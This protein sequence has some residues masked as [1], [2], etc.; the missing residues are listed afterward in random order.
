[1]QKQRGFTLIELIMV[2]SLGLIISFMAFQKMIKDQEDLT[3]SIAGQQIKQIG[4]AVNAYISNHY[5]TLSSLSNSTGSATDPGPRNCVSSTGFCTITVS[6]LSNEGLLP[7]SYSSQNIFNSGYSILIKRTGSAPYY[8]VSGL[9]TTLSPWQTAATGIRFDLLGKAMQSAGID[10]G[11]SRNTSN[12]MDGY[13][14]LWGYSSADF[15]NINQ[16]GL[17]GFITGYGATSY[18]VFLRRDGTLP[19]TGALNMGTNDITNAKNINATGNVIAGGT[20]TFGGKGTF[21]GEISAKNGYGDT[22][23]LGG[24]NVSNDYELR[25]GTNKPLTIYSP[26]AQATDT[27]LSVNGNTVVGNTLATN[28]LSPT[29]MPA[30][31]SGIRTQ[32]IYGNGR[33]KINGRI[34]TNGIDPN[35]LPPGWGGGVRTWD[36]L[37]GGTLA[38]LGVNKRG[39]D[40]ANNSGVAAYINNTGNVY[41]SGNIN[42]DGSVTVGS[43]LTANELIRLT[44][45]ST[46]SWGC[47]VG[48]ISRDDTGALMN[49]INGRWAYTRSTQNIFT[50]AA[51]L[52]AACVGAG[53]VNPPNY[54]YPQWALTCGARFCTSQGFTAGYVVESPGVLAGHPFGSNSPS[55]KVACSR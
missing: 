2:I 25:L 10:S 8:N 3:A 36:V 51:N 41:A 55:I 9:V 18:S 43:R 20:G 48:M 7:G 22:I 29:D 49:C 4:G 15:S 37:A 33:I 52:D 26:N 16:T 23:T 53:D 46:F 5:D 40:V 45:S 47:D 34:G 12:R 17:L 14:G 21:G 44:N 28:G 11:M 50:P 6:T 42:V 35:D 1:M 38:I 54:T 13:K 31:F 24:D 39:V 32:D 27:V 19:M 30:G